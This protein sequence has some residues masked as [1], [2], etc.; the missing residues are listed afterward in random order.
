VVVNSST[1]DQANV[2]IDDWVNGEGHFDYPE[3]VNLGCIDEL[4]DLLSFIYSA[5]I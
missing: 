4:Y 5:H 3:M 1:R 2:D